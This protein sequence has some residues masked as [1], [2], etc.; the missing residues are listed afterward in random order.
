MLI[1]LKKKANTN[2]NCYLINDSNSS[3][4]LWDFTLSILDI[5]LDAIQNWLF[6]NM[7]VLTLDKT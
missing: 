1:L 4:S 2:N 7:E 3:P 6:K 5:K